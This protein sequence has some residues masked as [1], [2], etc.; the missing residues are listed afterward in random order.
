MKQV[1]KCDY[2]KFMG[3]EEEVKEH[4]PICIDNYDRKSCYTCQH[5]GKLSMVNGLIKYECCKE[6]DIPEG[7]IFEFCNSYERKEKIDNPF[8]NIFNNIF[9]CS[10]NFKR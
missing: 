5:K 8:G 3:T 4:E 7:K 9:G 2:C 10:N 6:I 1:F